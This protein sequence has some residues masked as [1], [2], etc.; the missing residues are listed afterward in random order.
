MNLP[1]DKPTSRR[2]VKV[3]LTL[4]LTAAAQDMGNKVGLDIGNSFHLNLAFFRGH[5]VEKTFLCNAA[6]AVCEVGCGGP[7]KRDPT[8]PPVRLQPEGGI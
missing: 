7:T 1:F 5:D 4:T 3:C 6:V 2:G 8:L